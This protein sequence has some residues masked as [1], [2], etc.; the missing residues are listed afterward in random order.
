MVSQAMKQDARRKVREALD[1]R[2]KERAA[3][4]VKQSAMA[5]EL[6]SAL[7]ARDKAIADCQA[8]AGEL[9]RELLAGGLSAADVSGLCGDAVTTA[10]VRRLARTDAASVP[11]GGS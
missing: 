8:S 1:A 11:R 3:L 4:E 7:A 5:V 9:V 2:R 10:E 6:L